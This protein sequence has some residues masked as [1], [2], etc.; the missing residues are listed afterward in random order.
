[1]LYPLAASPA[2]IEPGCGPHPPSTTGVS[3]SQ[4]GRGT[5][6]PSTNWEAA[7][8]KKGSRAEKVKG[9]GGRGK[10]EVV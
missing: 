8:A 5:D 2:R 4:R 1:M 7:A 6:C 3:D 10:N 9:G